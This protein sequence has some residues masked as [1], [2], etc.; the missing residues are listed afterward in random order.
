MSS[1]TLEKLRQEA[2][3]LTPDERLTLAEH[4]FATVPPNPEVEKAWFEEAKRRSRDAE[5]G[6]SGYVDWE[7]VRRRYESHLE[8]IKTSR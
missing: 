8:K 5:A 2:A 1:I 3:T 4:L 6:K 7:N